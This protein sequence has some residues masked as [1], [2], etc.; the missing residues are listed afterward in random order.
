M[1]L[2]QYL[3]IAKLTK[4]V[5]FANAIVCHFFDFLRCRNGFFKCF[6]RTFAAD[7]EQ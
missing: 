1:V 5:D 4:K 6:L 7:F 3:F 2:F